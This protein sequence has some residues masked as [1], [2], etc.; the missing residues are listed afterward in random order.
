M[1]DNPTLTDF[2]RE[3][4]ALANLLVERRWRLRR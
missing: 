1:N 2:K 3:L 4:A